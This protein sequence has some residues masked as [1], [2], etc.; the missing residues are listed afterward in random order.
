M[1]QVEATSAAAQSERTGTGYKAVYWVLGLILLGYAV[2]L[3][4]RANRA[5]P[6][7]IDGWGVAA[8]ELLASVLVLIRAL[9]SPRDRQFCLWLGAGMCLWRSA[10][11]R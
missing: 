4:V 9:V 11:S 2:S 6:A 3:V 5:S 7:W 8:F 1:S 10:T